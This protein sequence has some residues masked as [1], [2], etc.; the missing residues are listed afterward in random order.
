MSGACGTCTACCRVFAIAELEKPASKWC[1][2]CDV[3]LGCTIYQTRPKTCVDFKCLWLLSQ[4]QEPKY[5]LPESLRPDRCRVV[6]GATTNEDIV[7][8]V[9]MP[10]APLAWRRKDV[11]ELI[12]WVVSKGKRV[13]VGAPAATDVILIDAKGQVPVKMSEPDAD[14]MQWRMDGG[15]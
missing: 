2:H 13:A 1:Q 14:G 5:P 10:G 12:R 7:A 9:T 15:R 11:M 3:G 8:A 4:E 6:F